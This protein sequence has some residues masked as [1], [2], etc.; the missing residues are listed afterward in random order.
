[1]LRLFNLLKSRQAVFYGGP[2]LCSPRGVWGPRVPP[3]PLPTRPCLCSLILA[4]L[5]DVNWYVAAFAVCISLVT[6]HV[7]PLF[8]CLLAI[9]TS[10]ENIQILCP[11]LIGLLM[12]L[13]LS[14]KS[15]L[16]ILDTSPLSDIKS[17]K[18]LPF[19]GL[20]FHFLDNVL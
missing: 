20:F 8:M 5:A 13:L 4:L 3:A 6:N 16:C 18:F 15:S 12:F 17:A 19:C 11:F 9:Y 10:L 2:H 1:M 7:E 14:Y